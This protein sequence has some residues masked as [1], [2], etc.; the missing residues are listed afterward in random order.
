MQFSE[1]GTQYGLFLCQQL[2][3]Q[4]VDLSFTSLLSV[5]HPPSTVWTV[6]LSSAVVHPPSTVWTVSLSSAV[7]HPPSTVWTVSLSSAVVHS[8]LT[9]WRCLCH[10]LLFTFHALT[11]NSGSRKN[12]K[13]DILTC[14]R[15]TMVMVNL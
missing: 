13:S 2:V 14:S 3:D 5:V 8:T 11:Q 6:S 15:L 9:V 1:Q 7:V 4:L 10:Q 12:M